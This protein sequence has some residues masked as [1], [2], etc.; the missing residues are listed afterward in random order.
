MTY[1]LGIGDRHLDNL[2]VTKEGRLFHI[3]FGYILGRDPKP[4]PPPMKIC[5]EM[6][7]V[8]GGAT[9]QNYNDFR[10]FT[11]IAFNSLRKSANLVLNLFSL[12]VNSNI[13]DLVLEPDAVYK[14][15]ERF[16][17]DL[18]DEDAIQF[19]QGLVNESIGAYFPQVMEQIHRVAQ[20]FRS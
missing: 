12:M 4:F 2:L 1:L 10:S 17:L 8:L 9:S 7:D 11:F 20:L 14:V 13:P 18:G 5:K 19:F 16:R 3:D 15:Q 6:V